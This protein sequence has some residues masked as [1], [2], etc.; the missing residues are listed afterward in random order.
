[1]RTLRERFFADE[2]EAGRRLTS[3]RRASRWPRRSSRWGSSAAGCS[4]SCGRVAIA[5][6]FGTSPN[7]DAYFVA[8]RIP[9]LVFQL[10][11]GA[12]LGSAFIPTFARV[13]GARGRPRGV[14]ARVVRAQPLLLATLVVAVLGLLLAPCSCRITAPAWATRPAS[15]RS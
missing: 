1:M 12:T 10:L 5:H 2:E 11:A 13:M 15:T 7:L 8:F 9:D 4:V 6:Q 3:P 14:A